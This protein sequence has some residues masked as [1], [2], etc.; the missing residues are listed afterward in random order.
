MTSSKE[1]YLNPNSRKEENISWDEAVSKVARVI[2]DVCKDYE[3][4]GHP[5]YS[6][7]LRE[8]F[9]RLLKG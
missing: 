5:Y 4:D 8:A 9:Q 6:T 2:E 1:T 3:K 7:F